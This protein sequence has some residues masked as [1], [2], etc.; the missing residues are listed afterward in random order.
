MADVKMLIFYCCM[1]THFCCMYTYF[2]C[3]MYTY[4]C[5][6]LLSWRN[7]RCWNLSYFVLNLKIFSCPAAAELVADTSTMI[8]ESFSYISEVFFINKYL[9]LLIT[10]CRDS[11]PNLLFQFFS[12]KGRQQ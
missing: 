1:Y 3:C 9:D 10:L 4:F 6:L 12:F 7:W 11:F 5:A 8:L 2:C